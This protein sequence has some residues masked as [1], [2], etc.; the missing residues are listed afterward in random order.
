MAS[1]RGNHLLIHL[2][3]T[4]FPN[5]FL[6]EQVDRITK[7]LS[8]PLDKCRFSGIGLKEDFY[9]QSFIFFISAVKESN[10]TDELL[11]SLLL[12]Y[13]SENSKQYPLDIGEDYAI[14]QRNQMAEYLVRKHLIDFKSTHC[15][16]L[17]TENFR[18][19]WDLP[20]VENGFIFT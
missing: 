15:T 18:I 17:T 5:I 20:T 11:H 4:R 19:P 6:T 14:E 2:L 8:Q 10:S 7:M 12:S 16:P 9:F 1:N 13:V 3:K